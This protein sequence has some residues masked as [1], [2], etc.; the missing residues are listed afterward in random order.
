MKR[1]MLSLL[2]LL[3]LCAALFPPTRAANPVCFTAVDYNVLPLTAD[4][5]PVWSGGVLYVPYFAFDAG[6]T[7]V[8]LG[9]SSTYNKSSGTVSVFSLRDMLVFDLNT[10]VCRNLHTGEIVP[11]KAI[12]RNGKA[13]LPAA[14]VCSFFGLS[15]P[16]YIST[17]YGY[18]VRLKRHDA[19]LPDAQFIDA[20]SNILTTRL[21]DYNQ[22]LQPAAESPSTPAKPSTPPPKEPEAEPSSV[23]TYLAFRCETGQA[24]PAIAQ[25]LEENGRLGL[26]FFPADQ[27]GAQGP[28][29]R[30]LLGGGH[31]VGI[32]AEEDTA[33]KTQELLGLGRAALETVARTRTYYALVPEAHRPQV[34]QDGW[35]CWD[36]GANA[37]PNPARTIYSS[38]LSTVRALPK[39]GSAHVT[40][41]DSQRSADTLPYLLRMLRE[42]NYTVSIPRETKL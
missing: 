31:S 40:M 20:A 38:A 30:R 3:A 15:Q 26:F 12:L 17:E 35:V 34:Q 1:R 32:L 29:I 25:T 8:S 10:G 18:L 7:G 19:V 24:A 9:T 21:R 23:P 13:Y 42:R 39:R 4:S 33:A 14:R 36:V 22:S 27:I 6:T 41:D 2:C 37:V 11:G 16:S 28:L 5:M